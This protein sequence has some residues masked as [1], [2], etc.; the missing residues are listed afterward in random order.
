MPET[1]VVSGALAQKPGIGGHTW[2]FL[3]YLLGFRRLGYDV[4]FVDRAN[5]A[6]EV[7][8]LAE[9]MDSFGL[10]DSWSVLVDGE[11]AG[12]SRREL[13]ARTREAAF[14]LNVMGFLE[15]EEILGAA[16]KRVFLDID[17]GFGQ[18]W[19][20]LGLADV[21]AGHDAHVTIAENMG[22]PGC[23]IPTC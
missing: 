21:F 2:V 4:V 5:S 18:M 1:I 17:P 23:E 11:A 7:S 9:V 13:R 20:E 14:L 15:D 19:R 10:G 22:R 12:I 8:Y 3:Q 16:R 6:A